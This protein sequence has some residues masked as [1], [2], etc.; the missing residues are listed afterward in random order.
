MYRE[1]EGKIRL[2]IDGKAKYIPNEKGIEILQK[3]NP[4]EKFRIARCK[5]T[6]RKVVQVKDGRNWLCLHD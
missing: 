4:A 2:I 5:D 3:V 1:I 6:K